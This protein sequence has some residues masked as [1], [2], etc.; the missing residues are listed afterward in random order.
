MLCVLCVRY[1]SWSPL[2]SDS[3]NLP[4]GLYNVFIPPESEVLV[5]YGTCGL[6]LHS[7]RGFQNLVC[8]E[9]TQW[10]LKHWLGWS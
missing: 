10:N 7:W 8:V 1:L 4:Q 2:S 9:R 6:F 3:S 5:T